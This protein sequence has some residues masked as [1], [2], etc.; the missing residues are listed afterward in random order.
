MNLLQ[1]H[2]TS[3][4]VLA[5]ARTLHRSAKSEFLDLV[6][7]VPSLR[8]LSSTSG[9]PWDGFF[10]AYSLDEMV[11]HLRNHKEK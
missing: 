1:L 10:H 3:L 8:I 6:S 5:V 11:P 2:G 7:K 4:A 9:L